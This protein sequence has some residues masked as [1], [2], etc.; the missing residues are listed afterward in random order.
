MGKLKIPKKT[1]T[2]GPWTDRF[3]Y[4]HGSRRVTRGSY[5]APDKGTKGRTPRSQ[6]WFS[7]GVHTGWEKG[8]PAAERRELVL[9]AF[10]GDYLTA[11]RSKQALANVTK[12]KETKKAAQS[13]ASYFFRMYRKHG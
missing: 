6:Q 3:G 9:D 7:P 5:L 10:G 13:D 8:L 1:Y 11:A 2:R 12:D 4:K